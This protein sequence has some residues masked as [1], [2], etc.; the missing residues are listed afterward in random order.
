MVA[1]LPSD[2]MRCDKCTSGQCWHAARRG[3]KTDIPRRKLAAH[4]TDDIL[5]RL[6]GFGGDGLRALR[7][8]GQYRV[9]IDRILYEFL[10]FGCDLPEFSDSH[11]TRVRFA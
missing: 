7:A 3:D 4:E 6:H 8:V 1:T 5:D 2:H 10:H 9:D 11:H